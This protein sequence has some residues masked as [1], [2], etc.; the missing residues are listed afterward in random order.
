V[1]R[2]DAG[3]AIEQHRIGKSEFLD[4]CRYLRDLRFRVRPRVVG[5]GINDAV[6]RSTI[7]S[8]T[9]IKMSSLILHRVLRGKYNCNYRT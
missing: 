3:L 7:W 5:I 8:L 9:L 1:S 6:S 4:R 2:H